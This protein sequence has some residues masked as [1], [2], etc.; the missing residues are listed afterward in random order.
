MTDLGPFS[1]KSFGSSVRWLDLRD[2][3]KYRLIAVRDHWAELRV[4]MGLG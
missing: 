3:A 4:L 1:A 2:T